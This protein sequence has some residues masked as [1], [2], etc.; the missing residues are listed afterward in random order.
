MTA[1]SIAPLT[2]TTTGPATARTPEAVGVVPAQKAAAMDRLRQV[3]RC[4]RLWAANTRCRDPLAEL[5]TALPRAL[6]RAPRFFAP[7]TQSLSFDEAWLLALHDAVNRSDADSYTFL[8]QT[9]M[10]RERASALHFALCPG[11][12]TL[13]T[14]ER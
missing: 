1:L 2:E 14:Q 3:A 5:V 6:G 8:L 13:D 9:R 12:A 11:L 4:S 10:T 7:G